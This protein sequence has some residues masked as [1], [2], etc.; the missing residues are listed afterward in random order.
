M[1][2]LEEWR[3]RRSRA[4]SVPLAGDLLPRRPS[5]HGGFLL[6]FCAAAQRRDSRGAKAKQVQDVRERAHEGQRE[7]EDADEEPRKGFA[8]APGLPPAGLQQERPTSDQ[9]PNAQIH[10]RI[11]QHARGDAEP[12]VTGA[13]WTTFTHRIISGPETVSHNNPNF[14]TLSL[15]LL[16][17]VYICLDVSIVRAYYCIWG[18]PFEIMKLVVYCEKSLEIMCGCLSRLFCNSLGLRS[19]IV[20]FL[21]N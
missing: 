15:Y 9:D 3:W 2:V 21:N 4:S 20:T 11:H 5:S 17:F 19:C 14:F 13:G 10:H 18:C 6:W 7:G 8:P 12:R 16:F 1:G